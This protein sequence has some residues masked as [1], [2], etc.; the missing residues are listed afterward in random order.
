MV[1][2]SYQFQTDLTLSNHRPEDWAKSFKSSLH[3][4]RLHKIALSASEINMLYTSKE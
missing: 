3:Q 4:F 2:G 1:A